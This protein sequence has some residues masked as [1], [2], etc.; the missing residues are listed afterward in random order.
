MSNPTD[1]SM[2]NI[3]ELASRKVLPYFTAKETNTVRATKDPKISEPTHVSEPM[4]ACCGP[5][6]D[7]SH[8]HPVTRLKHHREKFRFSRELQPTG[9]FQDP[10]AV[11]AIFHIYSVNHIFLGFWLTFFFFGLVI[12]L[13]IV[14]PP[15]I[16]PP[17]F[18]RPLTS[19]YQSLLP[20]LFPPF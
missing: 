19:N 1:W 4:F 18:F 8:I 20:I 13:P 7:T 9:Q 2:K 17:F 5:P 14:L 15:D 12:N 16:L 11:T 6:S 10:D 3:Q